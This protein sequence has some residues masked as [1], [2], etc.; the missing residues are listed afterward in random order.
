MTDALAVAAAA[1]AGWILPNSLLQR[2]FFTLHDQHVSRNRRNAS[3]AKLRLSWLKYMPACH[4]LP[5]PMSLAETD[6]G[7]RL[8]GTRSLER[9][10]VPY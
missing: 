3:P 6:M 10:R 2:L 9:R 1:A 4:P 7:P 5:H 8:P